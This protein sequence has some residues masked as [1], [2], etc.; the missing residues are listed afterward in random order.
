MLEGH[1][2]ITR[3]RDHGFV[4]RTPKKDLKKGQLDLCKHC[5]GGKHNPIHHAFPESSNAWGSGN[6]NAY[7]GLKKQWYAEMSPMLVKSGLETNLVRVAVEGE[8][9]FG[10]LRSVGDL[11]NLRGPCSKFL[12]DTMVTDGYIKDDGRDMEGGFWLFSFGDI[13]VK[14]EKDVWEMRLFIFPTY[15]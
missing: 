13:D 7:M 15:R 14:F 11:D 12:A 9:T 2:T 4:S 3:A 10:K 1:V 6:R 5:M 8:Y